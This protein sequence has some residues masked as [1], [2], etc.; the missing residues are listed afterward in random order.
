MPQREKRRRKMKKE[1]AHLKGT[2]RKTVRKL[3]FGR[4]RQQTPKQAQ[5]AT[6]PVDTSAP[7]DPPTFP[8]PP[9]MQM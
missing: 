9:S 4:N 5:G 3:V 8:L 2:K 7:L 6:R 1:E